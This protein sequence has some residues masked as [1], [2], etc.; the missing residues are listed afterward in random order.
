MPDLTEDVVEISQPPPVPK[1]RRKPKQRDPDRPSRVDFDA[2]ASS[3]PP[4]M[5]VTAEQLYRRPMWASRASWLGAPA[6]DVIRDGVPPYAAL[7]I[8]A[9]VG[10]ALAASLFLGLM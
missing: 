4:A 2:V 9:L 7:A 10:A 3:Y 6:R 8:S 1:R 5:V